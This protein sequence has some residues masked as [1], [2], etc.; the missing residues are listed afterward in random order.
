MYSIFN[1]Y[2]ESHFVESHNNMK[3]TPE[4]K[5]KVNDEDIFFTNNDVYNTK[6]YD[7]AYSI[8][9]VTGYMCPNCFNIQHIMTNVV[10]N[11]TVIF[12]DVTDEDIS[13]IESNNIN[14]SV[15]YNLKCKC[16]VCRYNRTH[17]KLD[18]NIADT[19][20]ILN[21]KGFYTIA[22][23]EGYKSF[24]GIIHPYIT[25]NYLSSEYSFNA[26]SK[27]EKYIEDTL[28]ITWYVDRSNHLMSY[29]MTYLSSSLVNIKERKFIPSHIPAY[30]RIKSDYC[31][32]KE[33][34]V[35]ILKWARSLP[36]LKKEGII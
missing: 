15:D 30:F 33:A 32:K 5:S 14:L 7:T 17:I 2:S 9:S 13:E 31:S 23:S 34:L 4:S 24:N 10:N 26:V 25:F 36:D 27:I 8:N 18:D 20:G 35:D 28:P 6:I 3:L 12:N 16:P 11:A 19:I 29:C 22:S 21:I 1:K